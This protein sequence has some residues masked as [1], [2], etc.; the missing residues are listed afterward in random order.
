MGNCRAAA[1]A[2]AAPVMV[3]IALRVAGGGSS[4]GEVGGEIM[5]TVP[6]VAVAWMVTGAQVNVLLGPF[7]KCDTKSCRHTPLKR[8][9][10]RISEPW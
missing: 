10:R 4:G 7:P 2:R 8:S 5:V 3:A 1:Q 6:L 9:T